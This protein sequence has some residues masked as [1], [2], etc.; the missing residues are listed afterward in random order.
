[1]RGRVEDDGADFGNKLD[2]LLSDAVDVVCDL[3]QASISMLQRKLRLGYARAAR[4]IDELEELGIV[5]PASGS[6]PREVIVPRNQAKEM[7][8]AAK[9]E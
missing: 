3:G 4:M 1:M 2:P 5:G 9:E 8:E 6:K 7:V